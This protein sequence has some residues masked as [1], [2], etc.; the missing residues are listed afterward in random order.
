MKQ[1]RASVHLFLLSIVLVLAT[2]CASYK[3]QDQ[4]SQKQDQSEQN[5]GSTYGTG[6]STGVESTSHA[7]SSQGDLGANVGDRVFFALNRSDLSQAARSILGR[8]AAWLKLNPNVRVTLEGHADERGTREY[9][10]ALG[11]RRANSVKTYLSGLGISPSRM[12]TISYG[13]ERPV[14]LCN[15]ERCWKQNRRVVMVV[16]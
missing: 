9:N 13:K 7:P 5:T 16:N 15:Q 11:L 12:H 6:L 14:A 10:I 3:P 1:N 8:Q 2:A 4:S